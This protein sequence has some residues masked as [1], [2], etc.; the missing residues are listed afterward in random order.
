MFSTAFLTK[1]GIYPIYHFPLVWDDKRPMKL[2]L[3]HERPQLRSIVSQQIVAMEVELYSLRPRISEL[4]KAL[5]RKAELEAHIDFLRS[6]ETG[7]ER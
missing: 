5:L 6:I 2:P 1:Y 7:F 4:E 3:K